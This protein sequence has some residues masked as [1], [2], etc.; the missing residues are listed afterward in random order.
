M[1]RTSRNFGEK[2]IEHIIIRGVNKQNIFLDC[3]DKRKF[4]K[5]IINTKEKYKYELYAYVIMP[6]HVHMQICHKDA[7]LSIIMNSLQT[8][9]ASYFNKKYERVGHLYQDRYFNKTIENDEYFKK[10]I[11]YI[12]KNPEKAFISSRDTY[13]WSSYSAYINKDKSLVDIDVFL[14]MLSEKETEALEKFKKIH[15]GDEEDKFLDYIEYEL[16]R[17]LTDEQLKEA[18][19]EKIKIKNIQQ[20]QRYNSKEIEKIFKDI[21]KIKYISVN[22]LSRVTGINRRIFDKIKK[23]AQLGTAPNCARR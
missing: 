22:Q 1:P 15:R 2:K 8:R 9:Y 13:E 7:D 14:Q 11:R 19:E 10:C 6:N 20:L 16:Q 12:H 23:S 21:V 3:Q 18:I 5:E 17:K 4:T